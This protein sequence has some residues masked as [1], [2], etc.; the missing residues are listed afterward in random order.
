MAW[1]L[2]Q[3]AQQK[4]CGTEHGVEGW[5]VRV[6]YSITQRLKLVI[7]CLAVRVQQREEMRL[8]RAVGAAPDVQHDCESE[9]GVEVGGAKMPCETIRYGTGSSEGRGRR[10]TQERQSGFVELFEA[11]RH[12]LH[13]HGD[14]RHGGALPLR[15]VRRKH[16]SWEEHSERGDEGCCGENGA[17]GRASQGFDCSESL[18]VGAPQ[19]LTPRVPRI[20]EG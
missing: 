17:T 5:Q 3:L 4:G 20:S 16:R 12:H 6:S 7:W 18:V 14:C 8:V 9:D 13:E 2:C 11:D 1:G 15:E 10:G 19:K